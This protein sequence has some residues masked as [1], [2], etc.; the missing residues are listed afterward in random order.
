MRK[1]THKYTAW[2]WSNKEDNELNKLK[3]QYANT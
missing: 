1:L 2:R 3:K